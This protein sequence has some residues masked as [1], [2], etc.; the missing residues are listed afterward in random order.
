MF[1]EKVFCE[2]LKALRSEM[3]ITQSTVATEMGTTKQTVSRWERGDIEPSNAALYA[4][5]DYFNV[6]TDY[7]LGRTDT[8]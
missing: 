3:G 5:A 4:L 7:L 2:R 6:S 8:P 1:S